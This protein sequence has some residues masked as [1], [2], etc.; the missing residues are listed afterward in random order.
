MER[1]SESVH[2]TVTNRFFF[3]ISY[4]LY[5]LVFE[6]FQFKLLGFYEASGNV[7]V[8]KAKLIPFV[9]V[10]ASDYNNNDIIIISMHK[11]YIKSIHAP[12]KIASFEKIK[13]TNIN[14]VKSSL[15]LVC[16]ST[17]FK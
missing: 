13:E 7:E 17:K 8:I 4:P 16:L 3:C 12:V 1:T 14:H 6:K 5:I 11:K 10:N 15:S 2:L 9:S